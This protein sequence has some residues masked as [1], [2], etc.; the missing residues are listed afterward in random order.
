MKVNKDY[1]LQLHSDECEL[2]KPVFSSISIRKVKPAK[3]LLRLLR[4]YDPNESKLGFWESSVYL[5]SKETYSKYPSELF[6]K[7]SELIKGFHFK[8]SPLISFMES[9]IRL[10]YTNHSSALFKLRLELTEAFSFKRFD[11]FDDFFYLCFSDFSYLSSNSLTDQYACFLNLIV[12]HAHY[13]KQVV[14]MACTEFTTHIHSC[15]WELI[16]SRII[17]NYISRR[18]KNMNRNL[19]GV[20]KSAGK[21]QTKALFI[22]SE[23]GSL[24]HIVFNPLQGGF[25]VKVALLRRLIG[26]SQEQLA[27]MLLTS[28]QSIVA[29]ERKNDPNEVAENMLFKVFYFSKVLSENTYVPS[30]I[31]NEAKELSETTSKCIENKANS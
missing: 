27:K 18:F 9:F 21:K 8:A 1:Y 13:Y 14:T 3:S 28:R 17:N 26:I 25:G 7:I 30:Y 16:M 22:E 12:K 6:E 4:E 11:F 31:Q 20:G 23:V 10:S 2:S 19:S 29:L 5:S 24:S 15:V